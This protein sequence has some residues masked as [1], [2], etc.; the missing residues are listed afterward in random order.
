MIF[1]TTNEK[2]L[3]LF[4]RSADFSSFKG[5]IELIPV[6]YLLMYSKEVEIYNRH[7]R[8]FSRDRH[9]TPHTARIA[10]LWAAL[11]RLRKPNPKNYGGPLA[12]VVA[13]MSPLEKAKLYD[14]GEVPSRLREDEKKLLLAN[15]LALRREYD[16]EEGEFEGVFGSEY[17]GRRGASAREMM[18]MLSRAAENRNYQC[19]TPMA[20]FDAIVELCKDSSLFEFL[21]FPVDEGY[22]DVRKFL[23]DVKEEYIQIVT[24]EVFDSISLIDEGEYNRVFL[25]YFR[26]VKAFCSKEKLYNPSTNSYEPANAEFLHSIERLLQFSEPPEVFRSNIMTKIGAKSLEH[27]RTKIDYQQIFPGILQA[28]RDNFYRERNRMLTLIEQDVLKFGTDEFVILSHD[29]QERVKDVLERMESKYHY[30]RGC[31]KDVIGYVLKNR[32]D[33]V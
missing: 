29:D 15:I 16:E 32:R 28:L 7:I 20:V 33:R 11:T 18:T 8:S 1:G 24:E 23:E 22:H 6:P 17:E 27:P 14:H 4:K 30:C 10:A 13:R 19:L 25:E 5:R 12:A 3:S 9:V 2:Q 21:R 26:H 31:A